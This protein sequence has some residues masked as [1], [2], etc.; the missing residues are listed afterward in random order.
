M[1][2]LLSI[3]R[4]VIPFGLSNGRDRRRRRKIRVIMEVR[5]IPYSIRQRLH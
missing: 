2:Y 3:R 4:S 5:R 1:C